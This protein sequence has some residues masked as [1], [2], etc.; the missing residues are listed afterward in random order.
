[1]YVKR[2][3]AGSIFPC[4]GCVFITNKQSHLVG[5]GSLQMLP[6]KLPAFAPL[7]PKSLF[8]DAPCLS[9]CGLEKGRFCAVSLSKSFHASAQ[10]KTH[11]ST[12]HH[13]HVQHAT[14]LFRTASTALM[15]KQANH[16]GHRYSLVILVIHDLAPASSHF[17]LGRHKV[18]SILGPCFVEASL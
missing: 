16:I 5:R 2:P 7:E 4:V 13:S 15:C 6:C 9:I 17:S 10:L 11:F 14:S 3:A 12:A 18:N 8:Y 1:M